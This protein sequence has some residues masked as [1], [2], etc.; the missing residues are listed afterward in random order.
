MVTTS[1]NLFL[2]DTTLRGAM[3]ILLLVLLAVFCF[4]DD[5]NIPSARLCLALSFMTTN[6]QEQHL[7][8]YDINQ[9]RNPFSSLELL[10]LSRI[11][12]WVQT[13]ERNG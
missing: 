13:E 9:S 1:L 6:H 3:I 2:N 5:N 11:G 4:S 12:M 10:Y 7:V 8:P